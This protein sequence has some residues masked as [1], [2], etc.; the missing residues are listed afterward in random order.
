MRA[1]DSLPLPVEARMPMRVLD[2]VLADKLAL[3][4]AV[5]RFLRPHGCRLLALDLEG[6]RP[7]LTLERFGGPLLISR[8]TN[9]VYLRE[10]PG[11]T[12]CKAFFM[13][14]E[15]EWRCHEEPTHG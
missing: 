8:I 10:E 6:K 13:G 14:C 5:T 12:Q 9:L 1:V 3:A 7:R 4:N 15:I 2:H 11:V